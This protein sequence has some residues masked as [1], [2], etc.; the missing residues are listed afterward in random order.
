VIRVGPAGW[1]YADWEGRVYP[2]AKPRGFHPLAHLAPFVDCVEVNASF[3]ATPKREH[4]SRWAELI[5]GHSGFRFVAKLLQDFTHGPAPEQPA[6]W[7]AKAAAWRGAVEPL[8]R[9][10]LLA[11]VLVQFAASF[12]EGPA[13]VLRLA[14]IRRLMDGL[15]LVLELRH[16]SWFTPAALAEIRGLGYSL[17][18]VDLPAAWDHPPERH[19]PTGPIGYLRLHGRNEAQWFRREAS[20]DDRYDYLYSPPEVGALAAR[21]RSIAAESEQTYVITNNHFEGQAVANAIELRWLLGGREPVPA[22]PELV[23]AFPHL[24]PLV[25]VEGQ[26]ELF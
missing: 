7:E 2:S 19:A 6:E 26:R 21:A 15:P 24:A 4:A 22:P 1:S 8:V 13:A 23:R 12:H 9:R 16:R 18:H 3:Y 10:H 20:R 11:A 14:E 5:A 17:A 25:R